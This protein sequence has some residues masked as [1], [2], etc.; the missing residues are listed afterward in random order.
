M[1]GIRIIPLPLAHRDERRA[2]SEAELPVAFSVV[3]V[4]L[5]A[6]SK[7]ARPEMRLGNHLHQ[8]T[9]E[10]FVLAAG[11][12]RRAT[13]ERDGERETV[14]DLR[15]PCLIRCGA[16]IGHTF[17]GPD[18]GTILITLADQSYD[19]A[20]TVPIPRQWDALGGCNPPVTQ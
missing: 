1:D 17:D 2:I 15:A 6:L 9:T 16:G 18:S 19:P 3:R 12:F 13:F 4:N 10:W 14:E 20:D 7:Q 11:G 5:I 8:T